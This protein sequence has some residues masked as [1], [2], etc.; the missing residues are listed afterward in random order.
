MNHFPCVR[1]VYLPLSI[2]QSQDRDTGDSFPALLGGRGFRGEAI[3]L[4]FNHRW[5]TITN[6]SI[7]IKAESS[8]QLSSI[9]ELV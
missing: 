2:R 6:L 8:S 4:S 7:T 5:Q 3:V 9:L 1:Q